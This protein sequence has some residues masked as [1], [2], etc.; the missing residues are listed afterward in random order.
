MGRR[1]SL[2]GGVLLADRYRRRSGRGGVGDL[3]RRGGGEG[4]LDL[5]CHLGECLRIL[6]GERRRSMGELLYLKKGQY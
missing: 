5:R 3:R 1:L 4:V 2:G 6:R